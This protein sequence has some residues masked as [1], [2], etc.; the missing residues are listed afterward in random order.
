VI[1]SC[2]CKSAHCIFLGLILVSATPILPR[3]CLCCK[4]RYDWLKKSIFLNNRAVASEYW[5][6]TSL[7]DVVGCL[8]SAPNL[9]IFSSKCLT[10]SAVYLS[11]FRVPNSAIRF[12]ATKSGLRV[13]FLHVYCILVATSSSPV[14][15]SSHGCIL[16]LAII[17]LNIG[18]I[19]QIHEYALMSFVRQKIW[20]FI[21]REIYC[22]CCI[23]VSES[24]LSQQ[25]FR[26]YFQIIYNLFKTEA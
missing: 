8:M 4:F 16:D 2:F 17:A 14:Y 7:K 3:S 5:I 1:W 22:W 9:L 21:K 24:F 26:D 12:Q 19:A 18:Q 13:S 10:D 25:D 6:L 15:V 11:L 23:F 20:G